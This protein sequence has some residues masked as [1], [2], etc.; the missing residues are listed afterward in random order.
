MSEEPKKPEPV[1]RSIDD[2]T[3]RGYPVGEPQR[4]RDKKNARRKGPK[5]P[6]A[7]DVDF[8]LFG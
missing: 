8:D 1:F 7:D 2:G 4:Y 6:M 5:N 3:Y